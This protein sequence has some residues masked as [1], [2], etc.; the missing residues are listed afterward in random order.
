MSD[1]FGH[2]ILTNRARDWLAEALQLTLDIAF[3]GA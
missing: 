2:K 1:Q 3:N